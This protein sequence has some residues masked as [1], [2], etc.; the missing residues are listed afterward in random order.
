MGNDGKVSGLELVRCT[1]VFDDQGNFCPFFDENKKTVEADQVI[2]A[3][4]QASE[5]AFCKDFCFLDDEG[6]LSVESGLIAI[7]KDTQQTEMKGV[8]AGG[9]AA[10][11]PATVIEAIATGRRAAISI[12]QY[13]GGNG[14]VEF[15]LRP[16]GARTYAPAGSGTRRRPI[17]RDYAA[18][19]DAASGPEGPTPRR[20]VGINE[21]GSRYD[22]GRE[23]GFAELRRIEVPSL[24]LS[25]RRGG[26]SEV[27]SCFSDEQA[28][29]ETHRCLQCDLEICLAKEAG[30]RQ[31]E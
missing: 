1:S 26:F 6:S 28:K 15:G 5:T 12:D 18:A 22:G 21:G 7:D 17:G 25:E 10:N 20:E 29:Q 24:P 8:F 11:G 9:D 13:L 30:S 16:I 4:G 23:N 3:I 2:L 27:E 31:K 14:V 19:K